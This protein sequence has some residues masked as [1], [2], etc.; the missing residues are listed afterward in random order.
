MI[1]NVNYY[2]L[3]PRRLIAGTKNSFGFERLELRFSDEW[4]GLSKSVTF[5]PAVGEPVTVEYDGPID[6]PREVMSAAGVVRFTVSGC[7]G[8]RRLVSLTGELD[9]LDSAGGA[10]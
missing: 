5:R 2:S 10:A 7:D 3:S 6:I 4:Q 1:I 8:E 9:V